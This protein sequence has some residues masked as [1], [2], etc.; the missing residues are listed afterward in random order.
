MP[1]VKITVTTPRK[2]GPPITQTIKVPDG[3]VGTVDTPYG[4]A[5]AEG[6]LTS[7]DKPYLLTKFPEIDK[8]WVKTE[9]PFPHDRS[10]AVG[11][12]PERRKELRH[13]ERGTTVIEAKYLKEEK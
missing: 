8:D 9:P 6:N 4:V 13:P 5:M 11:K 7:A 2:E 3:V 10:V 12:L 1:P